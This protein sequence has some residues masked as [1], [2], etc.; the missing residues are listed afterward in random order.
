MCVSSFILL[1]VSPGN[2]SWFGSGGWIKQGE[3]GA[4]APIRPI[5][6]T[7]GI[8]LAADLNADWLFADLQ[9]LADR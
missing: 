1:S 3:S 8:I 4:H 6:G 9:D 5:A 2:G 7:V